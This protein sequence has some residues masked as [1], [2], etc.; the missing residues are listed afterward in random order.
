MGSTGTPAT[1]VASTGA[2]PTP[3]TGGESPGFAIPSF[4]LGQLT[5]G[6]ENVDSYRVSVTVGGTEQY[7]GVV[8]TKPVLSRDIT[9][10]GGTRIIV[11][12]S[13]AWISQDGGPFTA[14]PP[15]L[16]TSMFM[17]FDPT[18]L[19]GMFSGPQWAQSSLEVGTE[20]KNGVSAKHL[21]IDSTTAAGGFT[22]IPAGA[23]MNLW[24]ADEGYLVA[25]EMTGF[26]TGGDT[27]IQVTGVDDP[28]NK[29][30]K[31]I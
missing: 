3:A 30:E 25:V 9:M 5:A 8:V 18:L 7:K 29:V 19:V 10:E 6:L 20:Q 17:M 28:A 26:G 11:I 21:L 24:I 16:A 31:P 15:E 27:S 14:A 12:G 2:V 4:D 1:P 13:E 23:S 22:G